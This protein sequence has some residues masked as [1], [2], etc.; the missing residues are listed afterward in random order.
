MG[1]KMS[2][3]SYTKYVPNS[4]SKEERGYI[5]D[6]KKVSNSWDYRDNP[7]NAIN[8]FIN[9]YNSSHIKKD[10]DQFIGNGEKTVFVLIPSSKRDNPLNIY[11]KQIGEEIFGIP[12]VDLFTL[13]EDL[14]KQADRNHDD[15]KKRRS[16]V[17]AT[18]ELKLPLSQIE[19]IILLDDVMTSGETFCA[20]EE[21]IRE[22]YPKIKVLCI[23]LARTE[24]E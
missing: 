1:G 11:H 16:E 17:S 6:L 4:Y 22:N 12:C 8:Y 14:P 19:R 5:L 15:R 13:T 24:R 10:V 21:K 18:V 7:Q 2:I 3:L 20:F 23:S 9:E